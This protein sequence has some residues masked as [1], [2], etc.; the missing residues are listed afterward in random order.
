VTPPTFD[1]NRFVVAQAP[2]FD[3]ALAQRRAGRKTTHWMWFIF[4]QLRG[5]GQ[6]AMAQQYGLSSLEEARAY[7]DHQRLGAR[8]IDCVQTVMHCDARAA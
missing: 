6:S 4:P 3:T 8:L 2:V 1:L 5:L 7:L